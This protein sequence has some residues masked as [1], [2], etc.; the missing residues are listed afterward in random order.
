MN[1]IDLILYYIIEFFKVAYIKYWASLQLGFAI[2]LPY[3]GS[4][5][6]LIILN[7]CFPGVIDLE[8]IIYTK[9]EYISNYKFLTSDG[10]IWN[11]NN[12]DIIVAQ[13]WPVEQFFESARINPIL[14][15]NNALEFNN[16]IEVN[17]V[18]GNNNNDFLIEIEPAAEAIRDHNFLCCDNCLGSCT[19]SNMTPCQRAFLF[20]LIVLWIGVAFYSIHNFYSSS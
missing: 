15:M 13:V 2:S 8:F 7:T 9:L 17:N 5:I 1:Q 10:L 11:F 18:V 14:E 4:V 16:L 3:L 20:T 12:S 6:T 19:C